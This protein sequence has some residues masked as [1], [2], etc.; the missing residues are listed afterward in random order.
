MRI[1]QLCK[2][3]PFPLKDGESLAVTYLSKALN[4]LGCEVTLLAMN[5]SK[6]YF[7]TNHLPDNFNHYQAI[8]FTELDNR[9][10]FIDA[11]INLFSKSSYHISRFISPAFEKVLIQLLAD[12]KFDVI[13]LESLYLAPYIDT[14]RKHSNAK[15]A[16]RAHNVEFEI[17]ERISF[18]TSNPIKKWYLNHLVKKLK[19]Y[20]IDQLGK[21]DVL[22]PITERDAKIFRKLGYNNK[23]TIT[24]IGID[25]TEYRP[26]NS[27][28]NKEM[29]IS[30]IGSLDW[31]PNL[32]G[33]QYFLTK[34]WPDLNTKF[35]N[36]KFHIAGRNTPDWLKS[37]N[38]QNVI[39]HGEV[40]S[41]KDFINTHPLMLVPLQAGSGMRAK[42][43][44]GMALG[45]VVVTTPVGLEGI[46]A[47][48]KEQVL[49]ANTK[50]EFIECINFAYENPHAIKEMGS[51]AQAY[52]AN[53]YDNLMVARKVINAYQSKTMELV[54]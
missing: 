31:I 26:D 19:R 48:H 5:T 46:Y 44:E 15:I 14:I 10:N 8:Y 6:H 41:A 27:C 24:P 23:Y 35:P 22:L 2:K 42:I 40:V 1:L 51:R 37:I 9:I 20:E 17:W 18:N 39:F 49:I 16:M 38:Y 25:N 30:F 36:L 13:Q 7:D 29:S 33:I 12:N 21:Y 50:E 47:E 11:F 43:L 28:F 52:V 45:K 54:S 53:N 4:D 3:F 34:I 32:E